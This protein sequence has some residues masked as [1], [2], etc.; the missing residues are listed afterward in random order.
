MHGNS[1][2]CKFRAYLPNDPSMVRSSFLIID[3]P[4]PCRPEATRFI[5][6]RIHLNQSL[7]ASSFPIRH[8]ATFCLAQHVPS[9]ASLS[10]FLLSSNLVSHTII[11]TQVDL[12]G[13]HPTTAT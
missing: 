11:T 12:K 7:I 10:R 13:T 9:L 6:S 1:L 3:S 4:P 2:L 8:G 5:H